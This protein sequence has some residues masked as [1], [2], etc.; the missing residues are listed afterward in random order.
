MALKP[1]TTSSSKSTSSRVSTLDAAVQDLSEKLNNHRAHTDNQFKE[2]RSSSST[3][4]IGAVAASAFVVIAVAATV[5]VSYRNEA[6]FM[7]EARQYQL[8]QFTETEELKSQLEQLKLN[9][10]HQFELLHAKN[11]YLK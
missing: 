7:N 6:D 9:T 11:S 3:I 4:I 8:N 5:I 10:E 1:K 2:H